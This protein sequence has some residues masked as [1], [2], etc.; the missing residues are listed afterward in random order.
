MKRYQKIIIDKKSKS[1]EDLRRNALFAIIIS[2][3]DSPQLSRACTDCK[4][5]I[6]YKLQKYIIQIYSLNCS[7]CT[8][9]HK[10]NI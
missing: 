3:L 2:I 6:V 9:T 5:I 10:V 4:K 8:Q 1:L 7:L